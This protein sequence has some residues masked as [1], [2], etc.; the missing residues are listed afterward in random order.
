MKITNLGLRLTVLLTA[1]ALAGCGHKLVAHGGDT[2]VAV[3]PDR[4]SYEKVE[5]MKSQ[6]GPVGM[7]GGLGEN[8]LAKKVDDKTPVKVVSKDE[9]GAEVEILDGPAKGTR[10][11]VA[12]DNVD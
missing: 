1:F 5:S 2:T 12:K 7:L 3:Y 8:F 11:Y 10:G 4:P 6:G 9:K